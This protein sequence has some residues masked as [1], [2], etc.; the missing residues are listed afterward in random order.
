MGGGVSERL[1]VDED[2]KLLNVVRGSKRKGKKGGCGG[3]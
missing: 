2:L 3:F 1:L